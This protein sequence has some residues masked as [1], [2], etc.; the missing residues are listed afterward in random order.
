LWVWHRIFNENG[1]ELKANEEAWLVVKLP[2]PPGNIRYLGKTKHVSKPVIS[3]NDYYIMR[4]FKDEDYYIF[5]TGRTDD[6]INVDIDC[7]QLKWNSC[8]SHHSVAECAVILNSRW[9]ERR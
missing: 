1:D 7:Q 8:Y 6:V 5:I 3:C 9:A 2:L 4:W